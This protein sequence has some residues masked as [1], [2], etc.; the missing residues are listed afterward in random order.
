[1]EREGVFTGLQEKS[2]E[3]LENSWDIGMGGTKKL[4]MRW[5]NEEVEMMVKIRALNKRNI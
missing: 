4:H 3:R 1:M 2:M 5:W